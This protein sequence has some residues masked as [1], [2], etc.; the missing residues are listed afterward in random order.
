MNDT[1][2]ELNDTSTELNDTSTELSDIRR[3]LER[4]ERYLSAAFLQR[5]SRNLED[6]GMA[7]LDVDEARA[8]ELLDLALDLQDA[9]DP[10]RDRITDDLLEAHSLAHRLR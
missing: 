2:T 8:D 4:I 5:Y 1:S 10:I 7:L 9:L 3:T 6:Q